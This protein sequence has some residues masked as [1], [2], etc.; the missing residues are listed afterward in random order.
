MQVRVVTIGIGQPKHAERYCTKL[1]PHL[2]CLSTPR[3]EDYYEYGLYPAGISQFVSTNVLSSLAGG[4]LRGNVGG[5]PSGDVRLPPG[6]F[7]V[8]G[9]GKIR[10][11]FYGKDIAEHPAISELLEQ[12]SAL[13]NKV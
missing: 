13:A 4:L 1:A 8:D 11:A 6:T 3:S 7:I 12:A 2:T 10:Y 9:A 5:M